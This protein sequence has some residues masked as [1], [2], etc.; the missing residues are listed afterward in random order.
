[1]AAA[2]DTHQA[3]QQTERFDPPADFATSRAR[4]VVRGLPGAASAQP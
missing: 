2:Q 4:P 1:M 3:S